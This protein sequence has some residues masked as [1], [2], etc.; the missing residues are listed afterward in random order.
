MSTSQR[1]ELT[2]NGRRAVVTTNEVYPYLWIE[3]EGK[4]F[5][6]GLNCLE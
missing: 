2:V 6:L 3:C 5:S 1:L 4:L